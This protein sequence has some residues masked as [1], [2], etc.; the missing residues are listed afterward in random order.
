MPNPIQTMNNAV[1]SYFARTPDCVGTGGD[2]HCLKVAKGFANYDAEVNVAKGREILRG[3]QEGN[4]PGAVRNVLKDPD[5]V[6][7]SR[8]SK[9]SCSQHPADGAFVNARQMRQLFA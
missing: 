9:V 8:N 7:F 4:H 5:S 3:E 2:K 1:S 6:H